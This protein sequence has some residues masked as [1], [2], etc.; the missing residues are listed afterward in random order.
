MR[1]YTRDAGLYSDI[2]KQ[3]KDKYDDALGHIFED[4]ILVL[5]DTE[6]EIKPP[7]VKKGEEEP[8]EEAMDK[9]KDKKRKAWKFMLKNIPQLFQDALDSR[10][11]FVLIVRKTLVDELTD[12]QIAAYIYSELRKI[13]HEYKLEKPDVHTFSDL[14]KLMGRPDWEQAY[15]VPNIL[16]IENN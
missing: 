1:R 13:N 7:K 12:A 3:L 5:I 6:F 11:Q 14:A 2:I 8:S 4:E 15:E 9:W 10:K 16:E